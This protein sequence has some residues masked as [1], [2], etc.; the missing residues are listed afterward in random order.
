M[1]PDERE[2]LVAY[3]LGRAHETRAEAKM[4][5][6]QAFWHAAMNRLFYAAF[7]P[8]TAWLLVHGLENKTHKGTRA[9]LARLTH[10]KGGIPRDSVKLYDLLFERRHVRDYD[11][12]VDMSAD[13]V[14]PLV[15]P[16]EELVALMEKAIADHNKP[17]ST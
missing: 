15:Q 12:F 16:T 5:V 10:E 17:I 6:E 11:D 9:A 3:R 7:Q 13:K 2:Q 4:L 8:V 1:K 14:L